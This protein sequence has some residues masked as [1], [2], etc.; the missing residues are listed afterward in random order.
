M[1]HYGLKLFASARAI[2]T[3]KEDVPEKKKSAVFSTT[4]LA[5]PVEL[6]RTSSVE[7]RV[8]DRP[9]PTV[10]CV[11]SSHLLSAAAVV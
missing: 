10:C 7:C 5:A 4:I 11:R 9:L 1:V 2:G 8:S 6:V 3:F